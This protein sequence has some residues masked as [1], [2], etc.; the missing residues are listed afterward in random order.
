[1]VGCF[2]LFEGDRMGCF[3]FFYFV[4]KIGYFRGFLKNRVM[5]LLNDIIEFCVIWCNIN[6]KVIL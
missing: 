5:F 6:S 2:G 3:G 4:Y 1:M